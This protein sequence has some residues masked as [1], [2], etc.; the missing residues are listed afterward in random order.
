MYFGS[1]T[2]A[3]QTAT[4]AKEAN[5]NPKGM[6]LPQWSPEVVIRVQRPNENT[7][8]TAPYFYV[9]SRFGFVPWIPTMIKMFSKE[10]CLVD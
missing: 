5:K 9:E 8:M 6:R 10:W 1:A 4:L 2:E 7:I 3:I